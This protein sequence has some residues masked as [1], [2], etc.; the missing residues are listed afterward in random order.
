MGGG[1]SGNEDKSL[2]SVALSLNSFA[3]KKK[4]LCFPLEIPGLGLGLGY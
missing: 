1:L 2:V 3:K 4:I